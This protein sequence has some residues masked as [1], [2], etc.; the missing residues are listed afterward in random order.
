MNIQM[1]RR[2]TIM[3]LQLVRKDITQVEADAIVASVNSE[4]VVGF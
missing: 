1:K 3:S 2:S 4:P